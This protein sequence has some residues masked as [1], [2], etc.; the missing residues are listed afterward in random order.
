VPGLPWNSGA[1]RHPRA[2]VPL[3]S[4]AWRPVETAVALLHDVLRHL[5]ATG[6][7]TFR[8][9]RYRA[10]LLIGLPTRSAPLGNWSRSVL[11]SGPA[12]L[13]GILGVVT[14]AACRFR[15]D[16]SRG[17]IATGRAAGL[18]RTARFRQQVAAALAAGDAVRSGID[19]TVTHDPI[20][21]GSL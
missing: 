16:G 11:L 3:A 1:P 2:A 20:I 18:R 10:S 5:V 13:A 15:Q 7:R 9:W 6:D 19:P 17:Q 21:M 8:D 12:W 4:L 14:D